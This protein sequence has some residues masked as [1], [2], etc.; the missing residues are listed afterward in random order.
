MVSS[1]CDSALGTNRTS[2]D[3]ESDGAAMPRSMLYASGVAFVLGGL[4]AGLTAPGSQHA[5][6]VAAFM[7]QVPAVKKTGVWV[8]TEW[9]FPP[10]PWGRGKA[11]R[12]AAAQCGIEMSVFVRPKIGFCNCAT[13]VADDEELA[14]IGD[15]DMLAYRLSPRGAGRAIKIAWMNGRSRNYRVT[16]QNGRDSSVLSIGF[17]DRCDAI[18]AT[19]V[20]GQHDPDVAEA[21]IL[22]L[23]NGR[24]VLGWIEVAIG[25]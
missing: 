19:A 9:P 3:T 17:N 18:V 13:G 15:L 25:L 24:R 23:L 21:A 22:E 20:I 11:F 7:S 16:N 5:R 1:E 6:S 2:Y 14:R 12:C 10:D 4:V 8:E